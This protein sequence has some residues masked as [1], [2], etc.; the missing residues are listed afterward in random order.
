M[1]RLIALNYRYLPFGAEHL[2]AAARLLAAGWD[3]GDVSRSGRLHGHEV[4]G[5]LLR[6]FAEQHV[7]LDSLLKVT[8]EWWPVLLNDPDMPDTLIEEIL[9]WIA[10]TVTQRLMVSGTIAAPV[11]L[12]GIAGQI[13]AAFLI[14]AKQSGTFPRAWSVT[15]HCVEQAARNDQNRHDAVLLQQIPDALVELLRRSPLD[16]AAVAQTTYEMTQ[17]LSEP[18]KSSW[19]HRFVKVHKITA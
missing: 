5:P 7:T 10:F 4:M 13:F 11:A 18:E 14:A 3:S 2:H 17:L 12:D 19:Q 6:Q 15:K 16:R 9:S 1:A 8:A